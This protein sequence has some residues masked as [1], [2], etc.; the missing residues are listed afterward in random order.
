MEQS[1]NPSKASKPELVAIDQLSY[2]AALSELENL[3]HELESDE[4]PLADA[5]AMFERGQALA[6]HCAHLLEEAD[7]KIQELS[8]GKLIELDRS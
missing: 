2:E 3:V 1:M 4:H 8:A 5:L 7:L 6:Q